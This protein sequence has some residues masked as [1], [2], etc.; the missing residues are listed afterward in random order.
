MAMSNV[1]QIIFCLCLTLFVTTLS[2]EKN[3]VNIEPHKQNEK[4]DNIGNGINK[5]RNIVAKLRFLEKIEKI[6]EKNNLGV[7]DVNFDPNVYNPDKNAP[8]SELTKIKL[9]EKEESDAYNNN[10][11]NLTNLSEIK[12]NK[13]KNKKALRLIVSEN[14]ATTPSFFE[15]SLLQE[16]VINFIHSKGKVF[17]LPNM[18]FMLIDLNSNTNDEELELY[19]NTLEN[20][21]A[22]VEPDQLV[23]GDDLDLTSIMNA[24]RNGEDNIDLKNYSYNN[25]LTTGQND[26]IIALGESILSDN[27]NHTTTK[28]SDNI[29][30]KSTSS[31]TE[32]EEEEEHTYFKSNKNKIYKFNDEYRN[33]QW[34][35]DLSK[36]DEAQEIIKENQ[37]VSTKICVIDSGVDYNHPDLKDN[38]DINNS[39]YSGK[40]GIDDDN[41]DVID[42]IYGANFVNNSGDPMDD[43][44]HGTHVAGIISA[45]SNNNIGIVGV[46]SNAKLII[47][48]ALDE[49]KIGRLGDIIKCIDYCIDRNANIINGSFSFDEYSSVFNDTTKYIKSLGILFVVSVGNCL[50]PKF[51]KPDLSKCNLSFNARYP[52]VL[53]N[54]H[55][56]IIAVGNLQKDL[57]GE[58]S[59]SP[60][61][62]YGDIYCQVAA[63]GTNIY[64]TTPFNTYRMLN[65]TSMASPHVAAIASIIYSIN[66]NLSYKEI[67]EIMKKSI[68]KV[69][70]V[71]DKVGWGGYIDIHQ[72]A[73]LAIESKA[74]YVQFSDWFK[75]KKNRH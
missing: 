17:H 24:V 51:M 45:I 65:G 54:I 5:A 27:N 8:K 11:P 6:L 32:E 67:I 62:F 13:I 50:H 7:M 19:I 56:N 58:Y 34:G 20:K 10:K 15:E 44:Y 2:L 64:S 3:A 29:H 40:K 70:A 42:D 22:H 60:N 39:E 12:V 25:Q 68:I 23:G 63:P 72:A 53:S 52:T 21:G 73:T 41:N 49:H 57:N 30:V 18:K 31:D 37:K 59:L 66:P 26:N 74:P 28:N 61:S 71:Q 16:D 69:P 4:K 46:D 36:L 9:N 55:D 33:L 38:I 48:K 14:H 47:C 43:N 75:W 35:L 1:Q